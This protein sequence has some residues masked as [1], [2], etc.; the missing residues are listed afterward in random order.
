MEPIR[1]TPRLAGRHSGVVGELVGKLNQIA[2]ALF[3][4][5]VQDAFHIRPPRK[6]RTAIGIVN[7]GR[8]AAVFLFD[9]NASR[10]GVSGIV[11]GGGLYDLRKCH[12]FGSCFVGRFVQLGYHYTAYFRYVNTYGNIFSINF[13]G[14]S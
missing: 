3:E 13:P 5:G 10:S 9:Y 4:H 8:N 2:V 6:I 12:L 7:A 1:K 14:R 11:I